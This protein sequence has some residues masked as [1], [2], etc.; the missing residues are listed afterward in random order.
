VGRREDNKRRTREALVE[1]GLALFREHGFEETRVQDIVERVGVSPATFFNYFPTKDAILEAQAEA[2]TDLYAALLR[3]ELER[4]EASVGARLEQ[5]TRVLAQA[6]GSDPV[7]SR[8]MATRTALFFGSSG[9]K[10]D[11][12]RA[13]QKL[14]AELFVQGQSSAEID[15]AADPLQLAELYS[16]TMMLTTMNWLTD[17][18]GATGQALDERLLATLRIFLNGARTQ[19]GRTAGF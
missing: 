19:P 9:P 11:K 17:W 6:L 5:I 18:F 10:A 15:A 1:T 8:L 4:R 16:A 7:I 13:S 14:L 3:H 12:D 2:A